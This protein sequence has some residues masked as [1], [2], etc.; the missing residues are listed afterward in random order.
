M[1][2]AIQT[3]SIKSFFF[4]IAIFGVLIWAAASLVLMWR[5]LGPGPQA[6]AVMII[7]GAAAVVFVALI[8]SYF[9][10]PDRRGPYALHLIGASIGGLTAMSLTVPVF[11]PLIRFQLDVMVKTLG[12]VNLPLVVKW[13]QIMF[14]YDASIEIV[15]IGMAAGWLVVVVGSRLKAKRLRLAGQ[16]I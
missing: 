15:L 2:P 6:R 5:R 16:G 13:R 12:A 1:E 4:W 7:F 3:K 11:V 9:F 10:L 14:P 8:F